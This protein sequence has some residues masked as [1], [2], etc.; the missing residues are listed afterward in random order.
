MSIAKPARLSALTLAIITAVTMQTAT[1]NMPTNP[2]AK[3]VTA[4]ALTPKLLPIKRMCFALTN[5]K[6]KPTGTS[7]QAG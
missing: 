5:A 1:A 6:T 7:C 2:N 3:P 4:A